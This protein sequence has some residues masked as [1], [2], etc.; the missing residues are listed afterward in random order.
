MIIHTH[1]E[2][3]LIVLMRKWCIGVILFKTYFFGTG[4]FF[5]SGYINQKHLSLF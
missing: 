2:K 5:F 1:P 4:V 3:K